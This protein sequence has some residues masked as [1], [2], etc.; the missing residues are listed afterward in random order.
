MNV[1]TA[2]FFTFINQVFDRFFNGLCAG[3]DSNDN[4][5]RIGNSRVIK[6][7]IFTARNFVNHLHVLFRRFRHLIIELVE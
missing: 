4:I 3:T 2:D 7:M 5:F 6:E 1:Y